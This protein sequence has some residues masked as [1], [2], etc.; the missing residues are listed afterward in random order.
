MFNWI[1]RD[2]DTMWL[3][4]TNIVLGLCVLVAVAV[5]GIAIGRDVMAKIRERARNRELF[6]YD[7]HSMM[8][9][10]LGLTMADGGEPLPHT[11]PKPGP[12]P[13]KH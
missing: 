6:V 10:D 1:T 12:N 13:A 5:A 3:T 4:I 9:P 2:P 7:A 8:L 11:D